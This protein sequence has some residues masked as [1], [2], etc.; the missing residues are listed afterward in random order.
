MNVETTSKMRKLFTL[1]KNYKNC[2]DFKNAE[3]FFKHEN[4]NHVI[5][6]LSSA[7]LSYESF[8]IFFETKFKILKNYLLENLILNCIREFTNRA[9]TSMFFV[10]KKNNN[11]RLCV[12]YKRLNVLIIK[13]KCSL[14]LIDETLNHLMNVVYFIKLD[15]KNAYHR[16]KIRK[17]D[18][19]MTTFCTR[20]DHFEYAIMFF[21][22]VNVFV[23]FQTLINKILRKLM[24]HIYMIYLNDILI[25]FKT[26][27]EHWK[28][29]RKILKCL[30]QF[31]LYAK[32]S[33]CFF[34]IQ[35]IEFFEYIINNH[36]ITMNSSRI[37]IIQT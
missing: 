33:K 10:F 21:E 12:N 24:N 7:K 2:F 34:M 6:L 29:V 37:E 16:I 20:Y 35:R 23:T 30:R 9:N 3:T 32:L 5:D 8:Y 27:E 25:Y 22:F 17:N 11:F 1:L 19:W 28:C 26:R 36:G 31:K 18:E 13:N 4:E 14:F 15:L